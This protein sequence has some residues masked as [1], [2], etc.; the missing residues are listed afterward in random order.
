MRK[1]LCVLFMFLILLP[2][3]SCYEKPVNYI[4]EFYAVMQEHGFTVQPGLIGEDTLSI[5]T[6]PF[7][8]ATKG[9]IYVERFEFLSSDE[10]KQHFDST[11]RMISNSRGSKRLAIEELD[12]FSKHNWEFEDSMFVCLRSGSTL[13]YIEALPEDEEEVENFLAALG[14]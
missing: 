12:D 7:I 14:Y 6:V 10:S 2:I 3:A 1:V 4:D 13:I 5:K 8:V 11:Y 9:N